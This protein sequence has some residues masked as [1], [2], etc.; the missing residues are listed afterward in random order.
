M[1]G[2]PL[3]GPSYIYEDNMSVVKNTKT[4]ESQLKKKSNSLCYHTMHESV[5]MNESW[6]GHIPSTANLADLAMEVIGGGQKCIY[7]VSKVCSMTSSQM[8]MTH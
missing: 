3:D 8:G 1:M 2:V 4:P 6:M 7:L 5:A